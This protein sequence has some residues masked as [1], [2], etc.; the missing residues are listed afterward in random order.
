MI[1]LAL[2][3]ILATGLFVALRL[4]LRKAPIGVQQFFIIYLIA[5]VSITLVL[6]TLLGRLPLLF[7]LFGT[8][9]PFL[10]SL[11]KNGM[12]FW[13]AANFLKRLRNFFGIPAGSDD[14]RT[15]KQPPRI[16]YAVMT[17]SD[18]FKLLGLEPDASME[19][20]LA[21]HQHLTQKAIKEGDINVQQTTL[22]RLDKARNL[23]IDLR[24]S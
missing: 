8:G 3:F 9:L 18:A 6:L 12:R 21:A 4:L 20:I 7:G 23:L 5:L 11:T 19:D 15:S 13:Q 16:P 1:Y 2:L 14:K 24:N 10:A 17:T 22:A